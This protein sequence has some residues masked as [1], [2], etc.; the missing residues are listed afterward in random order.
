MMQYG[1]G[2]WGE[3]VDKE[4]N[5]VPEGNMNTMDGTAKQMKFSMQQNGYK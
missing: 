4:M 1:N 5:M 3:I 2:T